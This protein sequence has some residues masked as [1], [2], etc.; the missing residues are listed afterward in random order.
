M[1]LHP[2]A[3]IIVVATTVNVHGKGMKF[4]CLWAVVMPVR[5]LM[6]ILLLMFVTI[7][8][9]VHARGHAC[10]LS[11]VICMWQHEMYPFGFYSARA[12]TFSMGRAISSCCPVPLHAGGLEQVL[13][14]TR[15]RLIVS[16][17]ECVSVRP[18]N[19]ASLCH[20]VTIAYMFTWLRSIIQF[21]AGICY[22]PITYTMSLYGCMWCTFV[23][24]CYLLVCGTISHNC[25][26]R[27][28]VCCCSL[29]YH[30]I[31]WSVVCHDW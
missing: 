18:S 31:T 25:W 17:V 26:P 9:R 11:D 5:M 4:C 10:H 22:V 7:H 14:A 16:T 28:C 3:R 23:G 6:S 2:S 30:C 29:W 1:K 12:W 19:I 15:S 20:S 24:K 13:V 27:L 21:V 8:V